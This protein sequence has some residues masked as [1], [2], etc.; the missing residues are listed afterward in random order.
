MIEAFKNCIPLLCVDGTF[1][2][3]KYRGTILTAIRVDD[4]SHV[5]PVAFAFVESENTSSWLQFL[6]PIKKCVVQNRRNVCVLDDRHAGL[7][8]TVKKL[9]ED[10][11]EELPWLDLHSR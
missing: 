7:L 11:T 3:G 10:V 5:V 8:L 1:M 2:A 6:W 4:D 9:N